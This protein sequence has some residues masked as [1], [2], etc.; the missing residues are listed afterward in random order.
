MPYVGKAPGGNHIRLAD[1]VKMCKAVK[2]ATVVL[3]EQ[4]DL[5]VDVLEIAI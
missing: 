2:D 1:R 4:S 5:E 3:S